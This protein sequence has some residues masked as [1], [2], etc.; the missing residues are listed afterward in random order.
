MSLLK[1]AGFILFIFILAGVYY[2]VATHQTKI[3]PPTPVTFF[4]AEGKEMQAVFETESVTLTLAGRSLSL[5]QVRSGSGI[6]Y[7]ATLSGVATAFISKG[8]NAFLS[9]NDTTT[10][11]DCIAAHITPGSPGYEVY[12]DQLKSFSFTLPTDFLISGSAIGYTQE[13]SVDA[14]T[15]GQVLAHIDVPQSYEPGTNFGDAKFTIGMSADPV[16]IA[17]CL[18]SS[19]GG[20]GSST[21]ST[22]DSIPFTKL[23]S[24]G[25]GAGNLYETTSYRTVRDSQCYAVEYTIHSMNIGNYTPG[26]VKA[27]DRARVESALEEVV[28]SFQF[29]P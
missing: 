1:R 7:E 24:S 12:S 6:R 23:T 16:A 17:E 26:A 14:T 8:D 27:F 28:H 21:P 2:D 29:L 15:T 3:A 20:M 9:E 4:C 5:P 11:A 10:Y 25:V 22:I 13:W 18:T 19:Y